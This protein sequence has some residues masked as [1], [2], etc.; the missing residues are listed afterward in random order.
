MV[1]RQPFFRYPLVLLSSS[2]AAGILSTRFIGP[3]PWRALLAGI[4]LSLFALLAL[5]GGRNGV[6]TIAVLLASF[7]GGAAL[8][9]TEKLPGYKDGVQN[10]FEREVLTSGQP[11][12]IT[13]VLI[14]PPEPAPA[15]FYLRLRLE[16]AFLKGSE[17]DLNGK[18]HLFAPVRNQQ[19][20]S[21]YKALS[22]QYGAR[23]RVMTAL[24]RA[25]RYRNPGVP[26]FT[27]YLERQGFGA[28]GIIKSPLLVE[29][30][31]NTRVFLP[32]A[33]VYEWR[34]R[35]LGMMDQTFSA[36]TA[37]VLKAALLGNRDS[38]SRETA[39]RFRDG[40]TFHVLV[41]SGLHISFIGGIAF[42]L[43]RLVTKRLTVQ[44]AAAIA[45]LW[46]YALMVGAGGPVI[47][48]ALM[49][50]F[51]SL[52]LIIGRKASPVN[53]IGAAAIALLLFKP[54]ELFNASFHLTFVSVFMIF[55]VSWPL[56]QRI[57]EI[58]SWHPARGTP[59]P[60]DGPKWLRTL[61]EALFWSEKD[62]QRE[63]SRSVWSCRVFKTSV[64][65]KLERW[66]VQRLL[67][68]SFV[69]IVVSASVQIGLLPL[70]I[71]YFNRIS[72]SALF[73]NITVG[74]LMATSS[75][76]ALGALAIKQVSV[77]A[78]AL[79]VALA[80]F[81]NHLMVHSIDPL[82]KIGIAS[83]RIPE[84]S[85]WGRAIY[86]LYY[87]P[88]MIIV[89]WF[90]RWRPTLNTSD[91]KAPS[92]FPS[93]RAA[94]ISLLSLFFLISIMIFHPFSAA[95]PDGRL[96]VDF[97]D[98]GQG[99]AALITMP[100]GTT[101]LIDG[102]GNIR[103][104]PASSDDLDTAFE[105]D[106]RSIGEAVV[107]EYLWWRG[108]NRIDYL[109]P[110]HAHSDHIDGLSD[111]ARNFKVRAALVARMPAGEPEYQ[112]FSDA[113]VRAR[114]PVYLIGKGDV[115]NIGGALISVL[116]PPIGENPN[117]AWENNESLVL[118]IK[119]GNRRFLFT[120]DIEEKVE[121]RL[122]SVM[123][124][125]RADVVKAPHHGSRTS[126]TQ[127]LVE[128][129]RASFVIIPVGLYSVFG[130]PHRGVV[131]RWKA[132]GAEVFTTGQKGALTV[133]TDGT[134]L[135]VQAFRP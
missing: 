135:N 117:S 111:I 80:E 116:W 49:F 65:A 25:D 130:H 106:S 72:L 133:S 47:R 115:L 74:F 5:R 77:H 102:G 118:Y 92:T 36:Q 37:S 86:V 71:L 112:K 20:L 78:A 119:F 51:A 99:D 128:A 121:G 6:S 18:V 2:I 40:G 127:Q 16:K 132:S 81:T 13:G 17:I 7:V 95:R 83:I 9:S 87:V 23:V 67:R 89:L 134:D 1:P 73:L 34:H 53:G 3:A 4:F 75:I 42:L 114:V 104:P 90:G 122:V 58:G 110:S 15:G 64:A 43:V 21:E 27:E 33:F 26:K 101:L 12:E 28:T 94:G 56:I 91:Q 60:P 30:L 123:K 48:A 98:V 76:L 29:R 52:A 79:P 85:G 105:K 108:L 22:L 45:F 70:M 96:R 113:M 14:R 120:G 97:L 126:S 125:L 41:I 62:W 124:D 50:S 93:T 129:T 109:M 61:G 44:V 11:V 31:D 66:H 57:Q 84:Y 24:Q 68:Y 8:A 39:E 59:K 107:S 54:S 69:A 131:E 35:L 55:T 38:L 19:I 32:L 88:L 103:F 46:M 63:L 82:L 10:L 100:D